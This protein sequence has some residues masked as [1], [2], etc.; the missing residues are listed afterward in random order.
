MFR[1]LPATLLMLGFAGF[2][3]ALLRSLAGVL[4]TFDLGS[5]A[6]LVVAVTLVCH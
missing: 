5:M 1:L 3:R 6:R 2:V 4:A